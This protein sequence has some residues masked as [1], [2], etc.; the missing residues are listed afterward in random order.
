MSL[1][2]AT[3]KEVDF[4]KDPSH[5]LAPSTIAR[6]QA[7]NA[8]PGPKYNV[9]AAGIKSTDKNVRSITLG[10]GPARYN[11]QALL[12]KSDKG[13]C[14]EGNTSCASCP[15][16]PGP[17]SY[18]PVAIRKAVRLTS[19][20]RNVSVQKFGT[21]RRELHTESSSRGAQPS[22]MTYDPERIR[23]G[24]DFSKRRTTSAILFGKSKPQQTKIDLYPGPQSYDSDAI[25]NGVIKTKK[26]TPKISFGPAAANTKYRSKV[27]PCKAEYRTETKSAPGPQH[28]DTNNIRRGLYSLS[29]KRR[30]PG[31]KIASVTRPSCDGEQR[32]IQSSPGPCSYN[33]PSSLGKQINSRYRSHTGVAFG[34]GR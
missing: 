30:P 7:R 33:Y 10:T 21:G 23:Q 31:I 25:V 18:D 12:T 15:H 8:T 9:E 5:V 17:Q 2:I 14:A 24:I 3:Q 28:Y 4:F 16:P 20:Q 22:P 1:P 6:I 34:G 26:S 27:D 32:E 11:D 19:K 13:K 29:N